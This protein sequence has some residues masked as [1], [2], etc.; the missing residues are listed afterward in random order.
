MIN[1]YYLDFTIT[2]KE[3]LILNPSVH[4]KHVLYSNPI[5][6]LGKNGQRLHYS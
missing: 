1:L 3:L 4:K 5:K 6:K 2:Y